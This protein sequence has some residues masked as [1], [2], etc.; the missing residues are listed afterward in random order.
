MNIGF[1]DDTDEDKVRGTTLHEFGHALGCIQEHQSPASPI[2]WDETVVIRELAKPPNCWDE[3]T[4]RHN[5][6]NTNTANAAQYR[7]TPFDP[8]SSMLYFF[9]ASWT[10]N[11][12]GTN[13]NQDL[14]RWDKYLISEIYPRDAT[15]SRRFQTPRI[16]DTADRRLTYPT[17]VG[18]SS[19]DR[20]S[21]PPKIAVSLTSLSVAV[22][23][24]VRIRTKA[25]TPERTNVIIHLDSW[26]NTKLQSAGC[27]WFEPSRG[28][29][30]QTGTFNTMESR[31]WNQPAVSAEKAITFATAFTAAPTIVVWLNWID[32]NRNHD[33]SVNAYTTHVTATGFT[34]HIDSA[35]DCVLYSGGATWIAFPAGSPG[36]QPG[37][38][39]T[40]RAT[41]DTRY[42]KTDCITFPEHTFDEPP[43]ALIAV[44]ALHFLQG[45]ELDFG[46]LVNN[47]EVSKMDWRIQTS[48]ESMCRALDATWMAY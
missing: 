29:Y 12:T 30:F 27:T 20:H 45:S 11:N 17:T 34:I 10:T 41:S 36:V 39:T 3:A 6:L 18:L 15:D 8:L 23:S 46:V 28:S 31:V 40:T 4:V 16:A 44:T 33:T 7:N 14:S 26:A 9:D 35:N 25:D 13:A 38:I 19:V 2:Q 32:T 5:V 22:D 1:N 43:K 48:R 42:E 47:V 37:V 24:N 21:P